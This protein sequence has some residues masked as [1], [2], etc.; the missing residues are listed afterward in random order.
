MIWAHV[1]RGAPKLYEKEVLVMYIFAATDP[2]FFNNLRYFIKEAVRDDPRCE[3][4]IVVQQYHDD[5][6]VSAGQT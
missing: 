1:L 4:V 6:K 3:Y 5:E 2:E